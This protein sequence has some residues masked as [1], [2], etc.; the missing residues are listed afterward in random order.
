MCIAKVSKTISKIR[1]VLI[2]ISHF[3]YK[4]GQTKIDWH[5]W[6]FITE[7]LKRNGPGEQGKPVV[8]DSNESNNDKSSYQSNGFSGYVS[9]KISLDRAVK[10]IRHPL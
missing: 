8:L 6:D 1:Y 4:V 9:D 2:L 7:E 10:D 5:D 3:Q